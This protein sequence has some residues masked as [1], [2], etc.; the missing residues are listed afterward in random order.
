[1]KQNP[2]T[3]LGVLAH[4]REINVL[5]TIH[6]FSEADSDYERDGR[7]KGEV[8]FFEIQRHT[9]HIP[10]CKKSQPADIPFLYTL[11]SV[12]SDLEEYGLVEVKWEERLVG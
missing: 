10:I 3:E 7:E 11:Y 2:I 4:Q 12:I 8:P 6:K 9:D 1:M 5:Q